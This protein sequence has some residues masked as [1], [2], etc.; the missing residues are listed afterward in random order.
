MQFLSLSEQLTRISQCLFGEQSSLYLHICS[1]EQ[2]VLDKCEE[3]DFSYTGKLKE[4]SSPLCTEEEMQ[5]TGS[6][7]F[8]KR[9]M[10]CVIGKDQIF[11]VI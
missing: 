4:A 10:L 7:S 8:D 3:D 2:F 1:K 11:R 5:N 6:Q 9:D